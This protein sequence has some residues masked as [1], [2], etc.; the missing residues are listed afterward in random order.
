L[1]YGH[2][3]PTGTSKPTQ[4]PPTLSPGTTGQLPPRKN[5]P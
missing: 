2:D 5:L 3:I 1:I 4:P